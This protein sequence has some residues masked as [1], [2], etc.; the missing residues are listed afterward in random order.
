M[1]YRNISTTMRFPGN[2]S[3]YRPLNSADMVLEAHSSSMRDQYASP[4]RSWGALRPGDSDHQLSSGRGGQPRSAE[5][6]KTRR[7]GEES[8][9]QSGVI[10]RAGPSCRPRH[11][12]SDPRQSPVTQSVIPG[13][14]QSAIPGQSQSPSQRSPGRVSRSVSDPR[15]ESVSHPRA[16]SVSQRR[17][18]PRT[19]CQLSRALP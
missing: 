3:S 15:T 4:A 5:Q 2:P 12:V 13:Q 7:R 18:V 16:E 1:Q 19:A 17:V 9:N 8:E 10:D 14:S 11:P 6:R